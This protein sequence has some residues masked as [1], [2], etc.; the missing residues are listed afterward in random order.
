MEANYEIVLNMWLDNI[1]P[2][3]DT[4][5]KL[6]IDWTKVNM[7]KT[8]KDIHK[9]SNS[10]AGNPQEFTGAKI[11]CNDDKQKFIITIDAIYFIDNGW[12]IL[13]NIHLSPI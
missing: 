8:E 10:S 2:V 3:L 5:E 13:G 12:K 9:V 11:T 7:I 4:A 1:I 6:R